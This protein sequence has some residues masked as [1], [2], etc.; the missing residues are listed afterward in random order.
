MRRLPQGLLHD[1]SDFCS[2]VMVLQKLEPRLRRSL[3]PCQTRIRQSRGQRVRHDALPDDFWKEWSI[4]EAFL[5]SADILARTP[6][7]APMYKAP[8]CRQSKICTSKTP[9]HAGK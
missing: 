2:L 6:K 4:K 7:S 1:K 3:K 5:F 9:I 8:S